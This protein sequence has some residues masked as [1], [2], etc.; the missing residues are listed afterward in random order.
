MN[1]VDKVVDE[2]LGG[3]AYGVT[4]VIVAQPFDTVKTRMQMSAQ[5]SATGIARDLFKVRVAVRAHALA[6]E[7][8]VLCMNMHTILTYLLSILVHCIWCCLPSLPLRCRSKASA[9]STAA[10]RH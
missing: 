6:S 10:R 5:A 7:I 9:V 4:S 1:S 3:F 8:R 2:C